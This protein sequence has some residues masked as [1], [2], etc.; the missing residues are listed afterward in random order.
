MEGFVDI[1]KIFVV[2]DVAPEWLYQ[3]W[4]ERIQKLDRWK[5]GM[6]ATRQDQG[7]FFVTWI[8]NA[9]THR[10]ARGPFSGDFKGI[11]DTFNE[12]WQRK[13]LTNLIPDAEVLTVHRSHLNGQFPTDNKL[14]IHYDFDI[15]NMWTMVYYLDGDDGNT[16]FYD[17]P[18]ID[19][20]GEMQPPEPIHTIEFKRNRAVFFPSYYWHAAENPS[21]GF[22]ISLAFAYLLNECKI[23]QE[24]KKDRG[25]I[26]VDPGH[27]D[28]S[29]F[30]RELEDKKRLEQ[31]HIKMQNSSNQGKA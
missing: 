18:K 23:N 26:E 28:L 17:N 1:N 11:A 21:N 13:H 19:D 9:G 31:M 16:I 4:V 2:D 6:A 29:D 8:S 7:R 25:I 27:P 22:R 30:L 24:L 5:Y 20:N 12:L 3:T 10:G 15:M 14:A